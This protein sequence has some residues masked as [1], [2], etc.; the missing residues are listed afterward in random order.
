MIRITQIN[1]RL[2]IYINEYSTF[3]NNLRGSGILLNRKVLSDI[4]MNEPAIFKSIV[5]KVKDNAK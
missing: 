3:I 2:N 4:A 1:N 5:E